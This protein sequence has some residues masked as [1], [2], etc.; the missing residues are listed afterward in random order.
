MGLSTKITQLRNDENLTDADKE[1]M[2]GIKHKTG[3]TLTDDDRLFIKETCCTD[4][5]HPLNSQFENF[6][7]LLG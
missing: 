1:K 4:V 7:S 3:E 6:F 2:E 5:F